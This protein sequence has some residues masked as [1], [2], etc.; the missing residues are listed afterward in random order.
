MVTS[1][2]DR[3]ELRAAVPGKRPRATWQVVSTQTLPLPGWTNTCTMFVVTAAGA[4]SER[5]AKIQT[6]LIKTG[7]GTLYRDDV[8][9]R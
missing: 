2:G 9:S 5:R 6:I 8:K 7:A 3:I 1:H 4:T